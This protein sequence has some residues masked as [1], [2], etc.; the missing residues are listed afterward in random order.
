VLDL[1]LL[2]NAFLLSLVVGHFLDD[3]ANGSAEALLQLWARGFGVFDRVVQHG[4]HE[5]VDVGDAAD[6]GEQMRDA[7][8]MVDIGRRV[9]VLA[10]LLLMLEGREPH[11]LEQDRRVHRLS[12]H[13]D[14][15]SCI[16]APQ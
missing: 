7:D 5:R 15:L 9:G 16:P 3:L 8:R 6:V 10:S 11:R 4:R 2:P 14:H 1:E 13:P 12:R